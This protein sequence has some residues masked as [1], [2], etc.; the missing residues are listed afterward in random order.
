MNKRRQCRNT[1]EWRG[2]VKKHPLQLRT[3]KGKEVVVVFFLSFLST[4]SF[5]SIL[6]FLRLF[7]QSPF[8]SILKSQDSFFFMSFERCCLQTQFKRKGEVNRLYSFLPSSIS[9]IHPYL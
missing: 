2:V 1:R 4:V 6:S 9:P 5:L 8:H 7:I 3:T